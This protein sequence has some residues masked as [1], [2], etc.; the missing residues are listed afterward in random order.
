M[1]KP[2]QWM[3]YATAAVLVFTYV[4]YKKAV[5]VCPF[6][7]YYGKG[8]TLSQMVSNFP[9]LRLLVSPV[10]PLGVLLPAL[11]YPLVTYPGFS[12]PW[13]LKHKGLFEKLKCDTV[14]ICAVYG[15]AMLI[16]ADISFISRMTSFACRD[17]FPKPVEEYKALSYLGSNLIICEGESWRRQRRIGA[18]AFSK[19]M[20]ER[21]WL[22]M[23]DIVREMVEEEKWMER[24]SLDYVADRI[25]TRDGY[26]LRP[27]EL[28]IPQVVDLTLRMALAAIA[29]AGFGMDFEWGPEKSFTSACQNFGNPQRWRWWLVLL[30][31]IWGVVDFVFEPIQHLYGP[32][33]SAFTWVISTPFFSVWNSIPLTP[34]RWTW[35][36]VYYFLAEFGTIFSRPT[37]TDFEPRQIKVHEALHLVAKDSILRMATPSVSCIIASIPGGLTLNPT[38]DDVSAF[39]SD[40]PDATRFLH[41]EGR[42]ETAYG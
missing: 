8:L 1:W 41:S 3:L 38:V 23:R 18:P 14:S 6:S 5:N 40:A 27:G 25:V 21:L 29:R 37:Q 9:G 13:M 2:E 42:I 33:F 4:R 36:I 34:L 24:T 16:T 26:V 19:G 32:V 10:S 17:I 11:P 15:R 31:W 20:F 39:P 12:F 35:N 30:S 28:L 22:D 7:V